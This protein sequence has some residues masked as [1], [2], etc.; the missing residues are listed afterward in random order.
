MA[1]AVVVDSGKVVVS[2]AKATFDNTLQLDGA[3]YDLSRKA[4]TATIRAESAPARVLAGWVQRRWQ[5]GPAPGDGQGRLTWQ[6]RPAPADGKGR[7]GAE[8]FSSAYHV[9]A[10]F[11]ASSIWPVPPL[12]GCAGEYRGSF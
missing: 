11:G 1:D 2:G 9:P 3:P 10:G 5:G 8:P 12:S 7:L 4:V 6:G